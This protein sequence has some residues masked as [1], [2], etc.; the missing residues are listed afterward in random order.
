MAQTN[1]MNTMPMGPWKVSY[2]RGDPVHLAPKQQRP[3]ASHKA[4]VLFV[5]Q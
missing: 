2:P 5:N 3:T 1:P 4:N